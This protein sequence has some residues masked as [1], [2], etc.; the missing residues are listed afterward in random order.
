MFLSINLNAFPTKLLQSRMSH[1]G[2]Q[3]KL[4]C[5]YQKRSRLFRQVKRGHNPRVWKKYQSIRNKIVSAVRSAKATYLTNLN[6][7]MLQETFGLT[8]I[9]SNAYYLVYQVPCEMALFIHNH[10]FQ[11]DMHVKQI[12]LFFSASKTWF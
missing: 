1:V 8:I 9:Q 4:K 6:S 12:F 7:S 5:S 2:S 10:S 11:A 3:E